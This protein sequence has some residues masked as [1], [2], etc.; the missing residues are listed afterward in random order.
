MV[1]SFFY[2]CDMIKVI[3][4]LLVFIYKLYFGIIF[5]CLAILF[6]PFFFVAYNSKTPLESGLVLKRFWTKCIQFFCVVPIK[7]EGIE[8]FPSKGGFVVASNHASY[9]DIIL[10]FSIVPHSFVFM[11]KAELLTWPFLSY[12][13]GKTDIPVD[14]INRTNAKK[15]LDI[16]ANKLQSSISVIIFP[17]GTMPDCSPEMARFKNGAFKL[18][19][20]QNVPIVP[21]TFVNNWALFSHHAEFFKRGKPGVSKVIVHSPIFCSGNSRED[22]VNLREQTFKIIDSKIQKQ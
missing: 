6:F 21:I 22:L 9:L 14:R 2:I 17:E 7:I 13:F 10:M 11:G 1:R 5:F 16:A 15:S 12:V 20:E 4:G 3:K 19:Q 18:A 8:H